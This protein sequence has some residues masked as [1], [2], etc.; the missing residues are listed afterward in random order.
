MNMIWLMLIYIYIYAHNSMFELLC[1]KGYMSLLLPTW[2]TQL[3]PI[4]EPAT[5][6][7]QRLPAELVRQERLTRAFTARAHWELSTTL[8]S[9]HLL[10]VVALANTLMS[11]N[12]ATF[13]PEQE[14]NRIMHRL[15]INII[16]F[17]LNN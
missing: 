10:A 8:T 9:N 1:L 16:F 6:L 3:E 5:Q 15:I 4:G 7:E 17:V 14:R 13:V 2:Q 11:M 12:N